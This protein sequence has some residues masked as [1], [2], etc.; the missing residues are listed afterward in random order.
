MGMTAEDKGILVGE[1]EW[2]VREG[3]FPAL[4][5][6]EGYLRNEGESG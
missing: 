5:R 6:S 3:D 2:R 1:L 4:Y